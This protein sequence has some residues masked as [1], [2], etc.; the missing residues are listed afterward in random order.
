MPIRHEKPMFTL[1]A[2]L[3]PAA[4]LCFNLF[5]LLFPG[6]TI[7]AARESL[8]LWF[9]N[10]LPSLLPFVIGVNLLMGL[11]AAHFISAL[12]EPLMR[13][14]FGIGGGGGFALA[15]GL[16]S[17]YPVGAKVTAELREKNVIPAQ[18][19][20]R[21]A[22]LASNAGPLFILGA[23][24]NG[25]FENAAAGWFLAAAHYGGAALAAVLYRVVGRRPKVGRP[26]PV[27]ARA[28]QS[29]FAA[30]AEARRRDARPFGAILAQSVTDGVETLL[31]VGGYITL[32]GVLVR[33][34]G[35]IGVP[36]ML[37]WLFHPLA[38]VLHWP[39]GMCHALLTGFLEMTNGAGLA[40]GFGVTRA[41][42]V[43]AAAAVSWGGLCVHA[44]AIGFL[45]RAKL[46]AMPYLA[47]KLLHAGLAALVGF[48]L[49]P[50]FEP[51]LSAHTPAFVFAD[52]PL[53]TGLRAAELFAA[54][55]VI[56]MLCAAAW[57]A[58]RRIFSRKIFPRRRKYGRMIGK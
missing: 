2:L 25:M 27:S 22:A 5:L 56:P 28:V 30:M 13:P 34:M 31:L 54:A 36:A 55:A 47:A 52:S 20:Q 42:L 37:D 1:S 40:S 9:R 41:G 8:L 35:L 4:A 53:A 38:N 43:A 45:S 49:F 50:L 44:Q 18:E 6:E 14:L 48:L 39:E 11:G 32:F 3:L 19:A 51:L 33:A 17:G 16:L 29:P 12:L 21:L 57:W 26:T 15:M 10:V 24:A 58:G 7:D 46:R 23:V